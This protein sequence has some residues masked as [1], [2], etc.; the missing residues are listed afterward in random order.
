MNHTEHITIR[1]NS[2]L[3]YTLTLS[4]REATKETP[5]QL[6]TEVLYIC[7]GTC[8]ITGCDIILTYLVVRFTVNIY[9]KTRMGGFYGMAYLRLIYQRSGC[10][11]KA[12]PSCLTI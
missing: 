5:F 11:K 9:G 7:T 12:V 10:N 3:L 6:S 2:S 4:S 8:S 1:Q